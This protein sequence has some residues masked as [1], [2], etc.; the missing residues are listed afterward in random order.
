MVHL[1]HTLLPLLVY[2][3]NAKYCWKKIKWS[4]IQCQVYEN[5]KLCSILFFSCLF[6]E[7][8]CV[9]SF[10]CVRENILDYSVVHLVIYIWLGDKRLRQFY[11]SLLFFIK[12][13]IP[14]SLH[15]FCC[16]SDVSGLTFHQT[17]PFCT[18]SDINSLKLNFQNTQQI[19]FVWFC[20]TEYVDIY[21]CPTDRTHCERSLFS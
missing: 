8:S 13:H 18:L 15:H 11:D 4:C 2:S 12:A 1:H 9:N 16:L 17:L 7:R 19:Y 3:K 21:N 14:F 10:S 5:I 6:W 20:F